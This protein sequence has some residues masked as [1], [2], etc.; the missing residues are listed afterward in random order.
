[1]GRAIKVMERKVQAHAVHRVLKRCSYIVASPG[2]HARTCP[3]LS[4]D[5]EQQRQHILTRAS[6]KAAPE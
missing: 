2:T 4:A 1:M 5:R 6:E 3:I